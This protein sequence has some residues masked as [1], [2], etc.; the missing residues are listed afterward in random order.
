MVRVEKKHAQAL[1]TFITRAIRLLPQ[2]GQATSASSDLRITSSSKSFPHGL[3]VY[4]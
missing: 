1:S 2:A 4:S 3:Q